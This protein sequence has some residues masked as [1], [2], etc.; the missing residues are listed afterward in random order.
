MASGCAGIAIEAASWSCRNV[1]IVAQW[2]NA[3]ARRI[4]QGI[5]QGAAVALRVGGIARSAAVAIRASGRR[6][7]GEI[8]KRLWLRLTHDIQVA[9]VVNGRTIIVAL[10]DAIAIN[11]VVLARRIVVARLWTGQDGFIEGAQQI[12]V[13][14]QLQ[15]GRTQRFQ[16][17]W[18]CLSIWIWIWMLHATV[19]QN[20]R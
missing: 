2:R 7:A 11:V 8:G 14:D 15:A 1:A 10:A 4:G 17:L 20:V 16:R 13:V 5:G 6:G 19:A 18:L 12:K 9:Y 3:D